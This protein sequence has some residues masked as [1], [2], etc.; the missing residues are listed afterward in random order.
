MM[1]MILTSSGFDNA[2][3]LPARCTCDGENA[4][5]PLA[6]SGVPAGARSLALV[7]IDGDASAGTWYHWAVY[8]LG[9]NLTELAGYQLSTGGALR[10]AINDFGQPGYGGA[11]PP[12]GHG[13]HHY[14]FRLYA[15]SID[16]LDL[17][18]RPGCRDVERA[19]EAH[20][21]ARAD[22]VGIYSR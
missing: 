7:C 13:L 21:L 4:S 5:P 10:Q 22:L 18:P 12:S 11:C 6:W 8:D 2:T 1:A 17:P 14:R 15:L 20:A 16:R 9:P 19:A 3:R